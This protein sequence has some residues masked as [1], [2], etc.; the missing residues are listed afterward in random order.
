MYNALTKIKQN[1]AEVGKLEEYLANVQL[2][3][4]RVN[5]QKN[6]AGEI[7]VLWI[8]TWI[9]ASDVNRTKPW[10]WQTDTTF[11]TNRLLKYLL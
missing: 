4:G 6:D 10:V 9:M 8:Q 11:S 2:E 7:S 5:W 1:I 3:G